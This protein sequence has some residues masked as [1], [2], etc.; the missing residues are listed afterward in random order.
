MAI[1]E[2]IW[3][4]LSHGPS[5]KYWRCAMMWPYAGVYACVP[6]NSLAPE[7]KSCAT[8]KP[9]PCAKAHGPVARCGH[10]PTFTSLSQYMTLI[11]S[12]G[13]MQ[14][15]SHASHRACS[16]AHHMNQSLGKLRAADTRNCNL[17]APSLAACTHQS[18][19]SHVEWLPHCSSWNI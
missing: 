6:V 4:S 10:V 15:A 14:Q 12:G 7:C 18:I 17:L 16:V 11:Q 3:L 13:H 5:R 1:C 19:W 9:G 2:Y 8:A